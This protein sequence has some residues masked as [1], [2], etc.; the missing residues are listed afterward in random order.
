MTYYY[1]YPH[2]DA[3]PRHFS[4]DAEHCTADEIAAWE[5]AKALA[6]TG[7][8]WAGNRDAL[9]ALIG[10]EYT[11]KDGSKGTVAFATGSAWGIGTYDDGEI[12]WDD[13][14]NEE[15]QP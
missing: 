9:N 4:P 2:T 5:Q 6:E 3:D 14:N 10:T 11:R 15:A 7:K 12:D 8:E 13:W 1:G